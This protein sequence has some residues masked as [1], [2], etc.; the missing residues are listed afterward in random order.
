MRL[1]NSLLLYS[2]RAKLDD[3]ERSPIHRMAAYLGV[4][5]FS[6]FCSMDD[7]FDLR[8][9]VDGHQ[10]N[11][12]MRLGKDSKNFICKSLPDGYDLFKIK[13]FLY[14]F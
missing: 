1:V 3:L 6:G 10:L 12:G 7:S 14:H 9:L 13:L 4:F 8:I 11:L 2:A 5:D